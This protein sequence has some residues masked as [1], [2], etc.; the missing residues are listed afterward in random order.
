MSLP[1]LLVVDDDP[2]ALRAVE[3]QLV[4]RYGHDYRVEGAGGPREAAE[5]LAALA[6]EGA[7]VAL[8]LTARAPAGDGPLERA[9]RLH[10]HAKCGLMVAWDALTDPATAEAVVDAIALGRADYYVRMPATWPDEVFHHTISTFLLEWATEQRRVPHTVHVV[11]AEWSGR[12]HELR[13][14]F[15]G[16]A[17][18]HTFTLA[19]SEEGRERLDRIAPGAKLPV[20]IMPDGS[21]LSDPTNAEIAEAAGAPT[22]FDGGD[23]DVVIVGAGPAGLSAAV[24]GAA[25]GLRRR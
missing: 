17:V 3:G 6:G 22:G 15:Q 23:F 4:R 1:V 5:V 24:Y 13:E 25:R 16:C 7:E 8:I 18:P 2:A 20:I 11:G 14:T 21:A 19:D 12:A 9:R 10:P